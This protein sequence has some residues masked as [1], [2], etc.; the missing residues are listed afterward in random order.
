MPFARA[1]KEMRLASIRRLCHGGRMPSTPLPDHR[2]AIAMLLLANLFWGLSFPL[3]KA[4]GQL[5]AALAPSAPDALLTLYTIAPRFLL[6]VVLMA[7]WRPR[8]V[9][10]ITACEWRQGLTLG[11]F[12]A[13]GMFLQNEGL[14]YTHASTSAFLTQLYA[15]LIPLWWAVVRRT[16]P[17]WRVWGAV[18]L[19]VVGGAVLSRMSIDNLSLGRGEALTLLC[20]FFFMGQI[21]TLERPAFR[22]NDPLRVTL[23]MFVVEGAVFW[24]A[25]VWAAGDAHQLWLPWTSAPWVL[26]TLALTVFCTVAAFT[27][28]NAWQ[29]KITSTEAGLIYC[30]EPLFGALLAL[31]VPGLIS[32]WTGIAYGNETLTGHLLLGGA[33]ITVANVL[34]QLAPPA[35]PSAQRL[36]DN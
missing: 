14:R 36:K 9:T 4:L 35:V 33:L 10:G 18:A 5:H 29:P 26:L 21:L 23:A 34:V 15:V 31:F 17:G 8:L 7:L 20:S 24:V 30:V 25:S 1:P 11:L 16:A 19:V 28:M 3:I 27:L 32:V 22:A 13:G 2:R 6:A 12:A